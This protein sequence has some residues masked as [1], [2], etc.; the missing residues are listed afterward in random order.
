MRAFGEHFTQF[1]FRAVMFHKIALV[2]PAVAI[3]IVAM[4]FDVFVVYSVLR[5]GIDKPARSIGLDSVIAAIN[6]Y[7]VFMPAEYIKQF[8]LHWRSAIG[9]QPQ[10]AELLRMVEAFFQHCMQFGMHQWFAACNLQ[11][12]DKVDDFKHG[13]QMGSEFID[14]HMRAI[15]VLR[16]KYAAKAATQIAPYGWRHID[17]G[18]VNHGVMTFTVPLWQAILRFAPQP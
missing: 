9:E 10:F 14:G 5:Q 7:S 4:V 13:M 18:E 15:L 1:G 11:F 6:N 2:D 3:L 12:V 8:L 17:G 16:H